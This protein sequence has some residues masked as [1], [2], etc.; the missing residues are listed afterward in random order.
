MKINCIHKGQYRPY[1]D[2][3]DIYELFG[4]EYEIK[5][6]VESKGLPTKDEYNKNVNN[7]DIGYFYRGYATISKN[8][9]V[10][11]Y[12]EVRPYVD[13]KENDMR[14]NTQTSK[15]LEYMRNN[16]TITSIEAIRL[17]GCTRLA[18]IIF[19]LKKQGYNIA[20]EMRD[21]GDGKRVAFYSLID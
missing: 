9:S 12:E 5:E 16:D 17:F 4:N 21:V 18:S 13:W 2:H 1:G 10:Y 15:V 20:S 6:Y 8:G 11:V 7:S 3:H 19:S 14:K